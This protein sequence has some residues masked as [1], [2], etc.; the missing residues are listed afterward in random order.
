[1]GRTFLQVGQYRFRIYS[2][3]LVVPTGLLRAL[4]SKKVV[5]EGECDDEDDEDAPANQPP[6]NL[7]VMGQVK[8]QGA[9][10]SKATG[11]VSG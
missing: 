11:K 2:I 3:F 8:P 1:M 7:P 5:I 9:A 4:A 10:W 6:S